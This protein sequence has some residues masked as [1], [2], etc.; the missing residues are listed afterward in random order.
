MEEDEGGLEDYPISTGLT[1]D[2]ANKILAK[3]CFFFF[4]LF[5]FFF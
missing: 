3:V 2:Q 1:T 4:F 5:I